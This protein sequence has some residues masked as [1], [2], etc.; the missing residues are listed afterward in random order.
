MSRRNKAKGEIK[1]RK[2]KE[3]FNH[4]QKYSTEQVLGLPTGEVFEVALMNFTPFDVPGLQNRY[5]NCDCGKGISRQNQHRLLGHVETR[6]GFGI[7][8][9]CLLKCSSWLFF[10]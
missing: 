10:F 7:T 4:S 6:K 9:F 5:I 3:S 8:L 1:H 2:R